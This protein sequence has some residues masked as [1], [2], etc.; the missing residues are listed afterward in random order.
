LQQASND[1]KAIKGSALEVRSVFPDSHCQDGSGGASWEQFIRRLK[2]ESA[3]K[4]RT[5]FAPG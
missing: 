2:S 1:Q 5:G 3:R 4:G